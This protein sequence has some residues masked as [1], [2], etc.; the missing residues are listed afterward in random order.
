MLTDVRDQPDYLQPPHETSFY[1]V[2][3]NLLL[4]AVVLF[5][6]SVAL[7]AA[8]SAALRTVGQIGLIITVVAM[9]PVVL[10]S[11]FVFLVALFQRQWL[12]MFYSAF[13]LLSLFDASHL[14]YQL[15]VSGTFLLSPVF[16]TGL[17]ASIA[18]ATYMR[19]RLT[20]PK[21]KVLGCQQH[22]AITMD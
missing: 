1:V 20:A 9:L 17:V 8:P 14:A 13:A 5:C 12:I 22:D 16:A 2:Y 3:T 10:S 15:T 19:H 21:V 7:S 11:P 6:T 4:L 18:S